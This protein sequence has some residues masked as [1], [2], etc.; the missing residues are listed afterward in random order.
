M[1]ALPAT[2]TADEVQF[3]R[4]LIIVTCEHNSDFHAKGAKAL[5]ILNTLAISAARARKAKS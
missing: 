5:R 2:I 3:V 1:S 4:D